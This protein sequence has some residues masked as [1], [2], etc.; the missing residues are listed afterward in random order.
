MQVMSFDQAEQ[1][2]IDS[3]L[4]PFLKWAGGKRQLLPVLMQY[5]P[6]GFHNYYEPFIGA[7]A[8][9]LGIQPRQAVFNDLNHELITTY[10]VIQKQPE[11]LIRQLKKHLNK[12]SISIENQI[13]ITHES[14]LPL[15]K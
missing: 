9:L 8:M 14:L 5:L 13:K 15:I 1:K 3:H 12:K 2:T 6:P 7:G 4:K 11:E 10:R